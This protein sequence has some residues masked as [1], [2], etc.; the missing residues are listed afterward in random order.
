[1]KEKIV[2]V[3]PLT[4]IWNSQGRIEATRERVLGLDDLKGMLS[5]FPV[6]FVVANPGHPLEWISVE[7]C[8]EFWKSEVKVHLAS[9]DQF[10]LE[11][12][13]GDYAYVASEWSGEL[14]TPV[15]LL[16]MYH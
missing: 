3:M 5:R 8:Y 7:K 16:E 4:E 10:S 11:E 6:E 14:Q 13:P 15:V 2:T 12:F 1:M 9:A